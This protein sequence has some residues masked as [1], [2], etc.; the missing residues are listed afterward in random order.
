MSAR[1]IHTIRHIKGVRT[2]SRL[3]NMLVSIVVTNHNYGPF[4]GFA[5]DSALKQTYDDVEIIVVDDGSTDESR[6]VLESY[7]DAVTIL[8]RPNA[9]QNA[10]INYVY[11]RCRGEVIIFLDSDDTLHPD[12]ARLHVQALASCPEAS[13]SQGYLR[14]IDQAGNPLR[15]TVPRRLSPSGDFRALTLK[16]GVGRVPHTY[17]SGCAWPRWFLNRVMP[18][19]AAKL[20]GPDSYLNPI[21]TLFG[22]TENIHQEIGCYRVHGNNKSI[23]GFDERGLS[24]YLELSYRRR[25]I[26]A[27]WAR[28]LGYE[29][30]VE[31]WHK[32]KRSWRDN[33][34]AHALE[35]IR[36]N[37]V[38]PSFSET[39]LAPFKSGRTR[40]PKAV[41]L[42]VALSAI[43][44]APRSQA[45]WG[46]RYLLGCQPKNWVFSECETSNFDKGFR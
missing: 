27:R 20:L 29:I 41:G 23:F 42:A 45:L 11:P 44:C 19:S 1:S 7:Q 39:V 31:A 34:A 9:G 2:A 17:T 13:K 30:D 21:S 33:L 18:M 3:F 8:L 36:R 14:V 40:W 12:A 15:Q 37:G 46:A 38:G 6:V 43:R 35:L 16:F 25:E 26:T 24:K 28:E 22:P 4:L 32:W 5:L 10:S